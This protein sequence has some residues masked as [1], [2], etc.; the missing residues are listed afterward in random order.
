M[1]RSVLI[2]GAS[3]GFGLNA[4]LALAAEGWHVFASMRDVRKGE[5][6]RE[7]ALA[8]GVADQISLVQLDVT[9]TTSVEKGVGEVLASTGGTLEAVLNNAGYSI[10]G[11]FEDLSDA[12]CR[13]Q[14]ETNFFGTLAVTRAV[15]PGM[16]AAGRGR[17]A[18]VTSNAVNAPH[19]MLTMYAASKWALEGWAEGLAMEVAPFGVEVVVVQ[20]GA[21]RTPFAEHVV[22]VI[23]KGSA[24]AR[25]MEMAM[26]GISNLDQWGRDAELA[27]PALV[28]AVSDPHMPFRT[29]IGEDSVAFARLKGSSPY[30]ARAWVLRAI[31]GLPGP[32]SFM[33]G[34]AST[35]ASNVPTVTDVIAERL[36]GAAA[37]D[38]ELVNLLLGAAIA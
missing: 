9:D 2:T 6:L 5:P 19:P 26:P 27:T 33:D 24:Y 20:P 35:T 3:S 22:P 10:L 36:S 14:M 28:A 18:I 31:L 29:A 25:W 11:A 13:R 1:T 8:E 23:P 37:R 15:L 38:P 7:R 12:D 4:A 34:A 17:I 21:H 16:R 32:G 30:E